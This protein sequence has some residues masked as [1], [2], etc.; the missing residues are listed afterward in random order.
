MDQEIDR[1]PLHQACYVDVR[2]HM[3][4]GMVQTRPFLVTRPVAMDSAGGIGGG[5]TPVLHW[6]VPLP[7][8]QTPSIRLVTARRTNQSGAAVSLGE[9]T[10]RCCKRFGE[11]SGSEGTGFLEVMCTT[12]CVFRGLA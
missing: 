10:A 2:P 11:T 9:S 4:V 5:G 6:I 8:A 12:L 7:A 3:I 1:S